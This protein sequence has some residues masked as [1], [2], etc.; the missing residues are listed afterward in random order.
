MKRPQLTRLNPRDRGFARVLALTVLRRLGPIDQ[1]LGARLHKPPPDQV[2]LLLRL[3]VAQLFWLDV[4]AFAA[5]MT[6]VDLAARD[7]A[8]QPFKG[9]VNGVLRALGRE[10]APEPQPESYLPP[11]LY[12]R[13]VT[14][15]GE[16]A[17]KAVAACVPDEPPT[18]L[19]LRDPQQTES[20]SQDLDAEVL[21]GGSLRTGRRGNVTDWP[22]FAEGSWWIQDAAAALPARLL[23]IQPGEAALD[24]CAAPGGKTLQLAAAGGRVVAVDRSPA[25]LKQ[26][27]EN[28][29]RM[30]LTAELVA[31][32]AAAW[33][34][35][36][37]FDAVLLDAPCS[38]TGT[39]R[40]HPDVLWAAK[41]GDIGKLAAVQSRLL[42][43]AADRVAP[44]GRLVY[45][46]C[47]LELEEGEMQVDAFLKR[48]PEFSLS[49]VLPGEGGA[50]DGCVT[51]TGGLRILPSAPEPKGG[52]DGFFIARFGRDGA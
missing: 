33:E 38:A 47:S 28:L 23:A 39:F 36:R 48:H 44:A 50:P 31:A 40:R 14:A 25:R 35:P 43:A 45:C 46:V 15:Y 24:L 51:S 30:R 19:S 11:W 21:P 3:G 27:E 13:W 2:R 5:V 34:D 4:P 16:P 8:S 20:L 37:R 17:A 1:M 26:L 52:L 49:P 29:A 42:D 6:T 32:D 12:A 7:P 41:P 9:L 18:D 10:G 22:G